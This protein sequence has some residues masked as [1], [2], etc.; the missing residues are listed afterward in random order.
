MTTIC[1]IIMCKDEEHCILETLESTL[2]YATEYIICDTGSTDNTINVC[3]NFFKNNNIKGQIFHHEWKNFGYNYTILYQLGHTHSKSE[4]LWQIDADDLVCGKMDI[5]NLTKD[6]YMLKF[7]KDFIYERKQILKNTIEWK[8]VGVIHGYIDIADENIKPSAGKIGGNYYI[9]SR[10]LSSRHKNKTG[11]ERFA[12]D[13]KIL[14]QGLIEEPNNTRYMFYLAQCYFD[15]HQYK[16]SQKAYQKRVD[17]DDWEEEVYYS[18]YRIAQ[19]YQNL[20]KENKEI[21]EKF[22]ECY[23]KHPDRA[24]PIFAIAMKYYNS[25][26]W[27][28][29]KRYFKLASS[30]PFPADKVLF[31]TKSIYDYQ[32]LYYLAKTYKKL[33]KFNKA[34]DICNQ[35]TNKDIDN[36]SK[37]NLRDMKQNCEKQIKYQDDYLTKITV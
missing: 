26:I 22:L 36:I 9:D 11:T 13:A 1:I 3:E 12:E 18:R 2:P 37:F 19:C 25:G 15:S 33:G 8:H 7:G 17:A 16:K 28:P 6:W 35:L 14:E 24:E 5:G 32:A 31:Q 10:R 27:K 29:A 21:I 30:I 4:Y 20:H 34:L 23:H